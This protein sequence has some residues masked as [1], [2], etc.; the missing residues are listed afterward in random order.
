MKA[1][2]YILAMAFLLLAPNDL[3]AQFLKKMKEKAEKKI[4]EK[5]VGKAEKKKEGNP[6]TDE[7]N[8]VD[9]ETKTGHPETKAST[10]Y[11]SKFDFVPG[12]KLIISDDFAQDAI[13]DFPALWFTN[14]SGEVVTMD[15]KEGK[16]L[17]MK[18]NSDYYVDKLITYPDDVTIQFD[19]MCSVPFKWGSSLFYMA[20]YD[21][22]DIDRFR[23]GDNGSEASEWNYHNRFTMDLHP[24]EP[25]H[26]NG[27]PSKGYG[28][29]TMNSDNNTNLDLGMAWMPSLD[30]NHVKISIWRQKQRLRVY[31]DENKI[32]DAPK[33]FPEG[34]IP[35]VFVFRSNSF[36]EN[37]AYFFSNFRV[38]VGNPDT[39]NKLLKEGKLVTNGI[40]FNVNSDKIKPESYGI[41]KEIAGILKES[42]DIKVMIVGHT[43]SDGDD[44]KNMELSQKRAK[45]VKDALV[46]DFGIKAENLETSG[47]GETEPLVPNSDNLGKAQNRR[48]EFTIVK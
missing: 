38:A 21:V 35:T 43:D 13:G 10:S 40:L 33:F 7:P 11:T 1:G 8:A 36:Y 46:T 14:G 47:K 32:I 37:D 22:I 41:L 31:L 3:S 29:Y 28:H 26:G 45:S 2:I 16:W 27:Y 24:G 39:R 20:M 18:N 42:G 4:E 5:L 48:V 17:I 19:L 9:N 6:N 12:E 44:S 25:A 34:Y 23:K 30:K 15:D